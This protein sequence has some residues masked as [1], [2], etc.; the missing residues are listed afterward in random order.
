MSCGQCFSP[1][2]RNIPTRIPSAAVV[3]PPPSVG[4]LAS[5][6]NIQRFG[7]PLVGSAHYQIQA[8]IASTSSSDGTLLIDEVPISDL[9]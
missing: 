7:S 2:F 3:L 6:E 5:R 8:E 1:C 4:K 9:I